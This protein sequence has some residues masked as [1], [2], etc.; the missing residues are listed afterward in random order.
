MQEFSIDIDDQIL[1][2]LFDFVITSNSELKETENLDICNSSL[3]L[4]PPEF[5]EGDA[6]MYF[7]TLLLHPMQINLTY[8]RTGATFTE[9]ERYFLNE[10]D[11]KKRRGNRGVIAFATDVLTMTV[12][13]IH[14]API[15]GRSIIFFL[16]LFS[17]K[18]A[19]TLSSNR[20]F[21]STH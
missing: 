2:A 13:N 17:S 15:R 8:S 9:G 19:R 12:G 4:Q 5:D 10:L 7:E 16:D 1:G 18:C 20:H 14:E 11:L 21:S 3:N 6:K